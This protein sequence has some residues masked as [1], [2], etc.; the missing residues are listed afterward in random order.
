MNSAA[1]T[2]IMPTEPSQNGDSHLE[3]SIPPAEVDVADTTSSSKEQISE[4]VPKTT[5]STAKK[6]EGKAVKTNKKMK[7]E[8]QK[9]RSL[10]KS[11]EDVEDPETKLDALGRKYLQLA[12]EQKTTQARKDELE[13]RLERVV[14]ERDQLQ[15]ECNK[16]SLAK[17]KLESLCRELQRHSKLV[18]EQSQL[19]SQEEEAKRK[20]LSE[21]FQTTINDIS[22]Q[23]QDNYKANQQLKNENNDLAARLK[24]L[25]EQ[26]EVREEHVEKVFKHKQ[27][28]LQLAEAKMAQQHLQ[29]D[30]D[31]RKT[32]AENQLLITR[33]QEYQ[34]QCEILTKQEAEMKS[35]LVLYAER[36]E[37]FQKTLNKSN[38]VFSTFKKEMDKMTKTIKKLE[39]EKNAWKTKCEGSNRSLLQMVE[40]R[41]KRK[42]EMAVLRVKNEKLEKLCRALHKGTKVTA[43]DTEESKAQSSVATE[44]DPNEKGQQEMEA[45][46]EVIQCTTKEESLKEHET[47]DEGKR[48]S[49]ETTVSSVSNNLGQAVQGAITEKPTESKDSLTINETSETALSGPDEVPND[50]PKFDEVPYESEN[51]DKVP[52]ESKSPDEV[53]NESENSGKVPNESKSPDEVPHESENLD[54]VLNEPKNLDEVPNDFESPDEVPSESEKPYESKFPDDVTNESENSDEVPNESKSPDEVPNESESPDEDP[55][56]SD[57]DPILDKNVFTQNE[58]GTTKN[59]E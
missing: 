15:S 41:E 40:D 13:K 58:S 48:D 28:E 37:D 38:E 22:E 34:K 46:V 20:E 25:A 1:D 24:V 32:L 6:S 19:R 12:S 8:E 29:F 18:K 59:G 10:L 31:K 39:K 47:R 35:Q 4:V 54:E 57:K 14:R 23:M 27:L 7:G 33:A 21:K 5:E 42:G 26:Y 16:A 3:A 30:E 45:A 50:S 11:F 43:N 9:L 2:V 52:N 44:N 36:F 56:T 53:R 17:H 55:I 49:G 51:L